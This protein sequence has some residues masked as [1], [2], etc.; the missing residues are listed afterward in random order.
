MPALTGSGT[1]GATQSPPPPRSEALPGTATTTTMSPPRR[2]C[3]HT[4]R[5]AL[6]AT[7]QPRN[8]DTTVTMG[9]TRAATP[10]R[11]RAGVLPNHTF[12]T[13]VAMRPGLTRRPALPRP[14]RRKVSLGTPAPPNTHSHPVLRQRTIILPKARRAPG[15]PTPGPRHCSQSWNPNRSR[16]AGRQPQG[17]SR[18]SR[19]RPGRRPRQQRRAS[20]RHSRSHSKVSG[21]SLRSRP[22]RR[23]GCSSRASQLP[24]VRP[25]LPA[26]QQGSLN[27]GP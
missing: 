9:G 20:R 6:A 18:P 4:M 3:G 22:H 16:K 19:R 11:S 14:C 17:H 24:G 2:A 1:T 27:Q 15:R 21:C 13:W 23:L 25:L 10:A 12:G 7:P 26:S 5:V 8:T